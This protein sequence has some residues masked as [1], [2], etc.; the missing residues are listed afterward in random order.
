MILCGFPFWKGS[1][2]DMVVE[3]DR[4]P[5]CSHAEHRAFETLQ[6][7]VG[8]IVFRICLRCGAVFQSP[9]METSRLEAFYKEGYRSL[10]QD[11][12]KP[13]EKDLV[14]QEE[15]AQRTLQMVRKDLPGI[16]RHLDIGSSSGALLTAFHRAYGCESTGIEPGDM[17]RTFSQQRGIRVYDTLESL[18]ERE[19]PFDFV[20]LMHVLE[21]LPDPVGTLSELRSKH[22]YPA[23][24]LLVEVPNLFEH[25]A[26][27]V[28][29]L[30]A[31]TSETLQET[32]RQAGFSVLW[33]RAHG[34]FRSP[35]LKLYITLFAQAVEQ[36]AGEPTV[37]STAFAVPLRRQF[38]RLKRQLLTRLLPD[39]T[40]QAPRVLWG[41]SGEEN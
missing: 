6:G 29:H 20:S 5:I 13:T 9:R 30:C 10:A 37:Q 36:P 23:G 27:E 41:D 40:W 8:E 24:N 38:G 7:E 33:T 15:R 2:Q 3:L 4:C 11:T 1:L 32:V 22:M 19:P 25:E 16:G 35:V 28:A 39:W 17:Y 31:F 26:L 18:P 14:M 12:E 34:S 21:H